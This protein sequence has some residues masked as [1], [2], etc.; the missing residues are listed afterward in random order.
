MRPSAFAVFML[1]IS[2]NL[3]GRSAGGAPNRAFRLG[4][5]SLASIWDWD[6]S[7]GVVPKG[8]SVGSGS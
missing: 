6:G 5:R 7:Q 1:I 3:V 4:K 2:L 8:V